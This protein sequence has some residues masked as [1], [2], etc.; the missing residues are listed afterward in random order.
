MQCCPSG[1]GV[2]GNLSREV[3]FYSD[4]TVLLL[5]MLLAGLI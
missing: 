2:K 1:F 3:C 5:K 4:D